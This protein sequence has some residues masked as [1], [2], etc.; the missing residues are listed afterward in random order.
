MWLVQDPR[1]LAE[2]DRDI[3]RKEQLLAQYDAKVC[4]A[5]VCPCSQLAL[6]ECSRPSSSILPQVAAE[7]AAGDVPEF[8]EEEDDY[9]YDM[10]QDMATGG[11]DEPAQS[12]GASP[13]QSQGYGGAAQG[14]GYG[15]P[16]SYDAQDSYGAPQQYEPEPVYDEPPRRG[17][18]PSAAR[19]GEPAAARGGAAPRGAPAQSFDP[20]AASG[21]GPGGPDGGPAD[22]PPARG[23]PAPSPY[24]GAPQETQQPSRGSPA[25]GPLR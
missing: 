10:P 25:A 23:S 1:F 24:G 14:G 2:E 9:G 19:G 8:Q 18:A 21:P 5:L 15:G 11:Y 4:H 13:A 6:G 3:I 20:Y 22:A 16:D 17:G 12:Y 7:R